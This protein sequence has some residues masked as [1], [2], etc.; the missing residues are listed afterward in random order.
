M[1]AAPGSV[2]RLCRQS[3]RRTAE[4][5]P[6]ARR[7][8]ARHSRSRCPGSR[9]PG[10]VLPPPPRASTPRVVQVGVLFTPEHHEPVAGRPWDEGRVRAAVETIVA[11]TLASQRP[12]GFWPEHPDDVSKD[13][14]SVRTGIYMGAAGLVWALHQLGHDLTGTAERLHERYL[15][16]PDW[17]GVVPG[18]LMGEAGILFTAHQ[19]APDAGRADALERAVAENA[20]NESNELMW[21]APGTMMVAQAAVGGARLRPVDA[22][23]VRP[24]GAIRRAGTRIRRQRPRPLA[25]RRTPQRR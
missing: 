2:S 14:T 12:D 5:A 13:R 9:R 24:G 15:A 1:T 10:S 23:A 25:G 6:C 18:F 4:V 19:L 17:P 16:E 20:G 21:G 7:H 11:D 3:P 22:A 8:P